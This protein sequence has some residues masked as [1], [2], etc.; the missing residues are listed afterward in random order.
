MAVYWVRNDLQKKAAQ[1]SGFFNYD[2]LINR[3]NRQRT[4]LH[5][6]KNHFL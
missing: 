2:S 5:H 1:M 4:F 3:L 6:Q